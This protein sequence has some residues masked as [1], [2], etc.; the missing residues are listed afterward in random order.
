MANTSRITD[1]DDRRIEAYR[2]IRERDLVG[3]QGKFIAEGKVVLRAL[4]KSPHF[5]TESILLLENRLAGLRG[6]LELAPSGVPVY[7]ASRDV[8]DNIV[9]YPIHRGVLAIGNRVD[10]DRRTYKPPESDR[11]CLLVVCAGISNHD[12]IGSI[13][14]IAAAFA[15][16]AILLDDRS[17][18]PLYRKALRV[19]VGAALSIPFR[20]QGGIAEIIGMLKESG[21]TPISLSPSGQEFLSDVRPPSRT[22]IILGSEGNGLSAEV[23]SMTRSLRIAMAPGFDSLNVAAASAIALH[24]FSQE[25]V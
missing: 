21:I 23:L 3:R 6:D 1:P 7:V 14:R 10:S 11:P 16:D 20:R 15:A 4:L 22:A 8:I 13:F 17:S 2:D 5:A 12:N 19:S 18:D 9:G 25:R 24:H